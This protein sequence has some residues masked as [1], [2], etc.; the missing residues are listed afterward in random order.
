MQAAA[1]GATIVN[2]GQSAGATSDLA[3]GPVRFK[4]LSILGHTNFALP[5]DELVEHY[6]RL[7]GHAMAGEIALDVERVPLED[8]ADAWQRQADGPGTKLV[9]VP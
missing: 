2:L 5:H 9:V 1:P 4:N 6:S 7:V 8:V 3:S